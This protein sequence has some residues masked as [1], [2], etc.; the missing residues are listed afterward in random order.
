[1]ASRVTILAS[2]L[3]VLGGVVLTLALFRQMDLG[4]APPI[5]IRDPLVDTEIIVA[6]AGA[7]ASPGVVRL[8][9][10]ARWGDAIVAAGGALAGADLTT[11]NQAQRLSDGDRVVVPT[12]PG[13]G[14]PVTG[15]ITDE[16]GPPPTTSADETD[17][18]AERT[19]VPRPTPAPSTVASTDAPLDL[20]QATAEELEALPEIGAVLADRIIA[21]RDQVGRFSSI[22]ELADVEGISDRMVAVLRPLVTV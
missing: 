16:G 5:V 10:E 9:A 2:L 11:V 7:V 18:G 15:A 12:R 22:D 1:M 14:A 3:A 17:L 13:D 8:P 6:V 19:I 21:Y 20:N 4:D